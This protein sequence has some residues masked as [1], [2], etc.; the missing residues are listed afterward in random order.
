[1]GQSGRLEVA[2]YSESV[3]SESCMK[4]GDS[5]GAAWECI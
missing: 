3:R 2:I 5:V 1:V 4:N